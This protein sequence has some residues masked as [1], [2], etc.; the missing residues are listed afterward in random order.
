MIT[1]NE[2]RDIAKA[3]TLEEQLIEHLDYA[4]GTIRAAA[5]QKKFETKLMTEFWANE[6]YH[7]TKLY[8]LAVEKLKESGFDVEYIYEDDQFA[9][10]HTNV[11]WKVE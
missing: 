7:N 9:I 5:E 8:K 2:A 11:S 10:M 1:A 4:Y 6:G 3:L